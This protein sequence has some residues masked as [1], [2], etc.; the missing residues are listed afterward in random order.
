MCDCPQL[1]LYSERSATLAPKQTLAAMGSHKAMA[2]ELHPGDSEGVDAKRRA[3][4][5]SRVAFGRQ[6][7]S[8]RGRALAERAAPVARKARAPKRCQNDTHAHTLKNLR[9][10]RVLA[11]VFPFARL[12]KPKVAV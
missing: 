3:K 8:S 12:S 6:D 4:T 1:A 5:P 11:L 9:G 7:D 10:L 2:I